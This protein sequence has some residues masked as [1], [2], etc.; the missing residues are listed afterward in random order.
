M[1]FFFVD[2]RLAT[3]I[4]VLAPSGKVLKVGEPSEKIGI[5]RSDLTP[6]ISV[7]AL[8]PP[9]PGSRAPR[10]LPITPIADASLRAPSIIIGQVVGRY[11]AGRMSALPNIVNGIDFIRIHNWS[12]SPLFLRTFDYARKELDPIRVLPG[13]IVFFKGPGS[14]GVPYGF[15]ITDA[16]GIF[17][18]YEVLEEITDLYFG[19]TSFSPQP[20]IA[21]TEG[22]YDPPPYDP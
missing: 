1:A 14:R 11:Q 6:G 7:V 5:R 8:L 18:P 3:R 9:S 4:A 20:L 2:N 12:A 13:T 19:V 16:L 10:P 22:Y 17:P 15:K 21:G